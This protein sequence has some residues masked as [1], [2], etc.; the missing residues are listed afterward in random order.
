MPQ[1]PLSSFGAQQL[2]LNQSQYQRSFACHTCS[3]RLSNPWTYPYSWYWLDTFPASY[4]PRCEA[5]AVWRFQHWL[6]RDWFRYIWPEST[7]IQCMAILFWLQRLAKVSFFFAPARHAKLESQHA[8]SSSPTMCYRYDFN[9]SGPRTLSTT[10]YYHILVRSLTCYHVL[11]PPT[12]V[13][14]LRTTTC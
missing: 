7:A 8:S 1:R 6:L 2:N 3:C 5:Q 9:R 14:L 12:V 4:N 11:R 13:L 10:R